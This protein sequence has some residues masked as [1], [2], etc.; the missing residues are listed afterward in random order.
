MFER[1][2]FMST[3]TAWHAVAQGTSVQEAMQNSRQCLEAC[4]SSN[5]N[6]EGGSFLH[7]QTTN[8]VTLC[9]IIRFQWSASFVPAIVPLS[10]APASMKPVRRRMALRCISRSR[11]SDALGDMPPIDTP[12]MLIR[13]SCMH[14]L[15]SADIFV[16][17][18]LYGH[19]T[20]EVQSSCTT[21]IS[22][23]SRNKLPCEEGSSLAGIPGGAGG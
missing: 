16:L 19:D 20:S 10:A 13:F 23:S 5:K 8:G 12:C 22:Q 1:V 7:M 9:T 14:V 2:N 11:F 3:P 15:S 18:T 4:C 21:S 17:K 6:T